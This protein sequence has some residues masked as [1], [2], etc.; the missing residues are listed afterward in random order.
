MTRFLLLCICICISTSSFSQTTV[1]KDVHFNNYINSL[2]NDFTNYFTGFNTGITQLQTNGI[3]GGCIATPDS[4]NWGNDNAH[5]CTKFKAIV[6][7]SYSFNTSFCFKYD[8]TI[9]NP[10]SFDR[11]ASIWIIPNADFN[12]YLI[13]SITHDKKIQVIS[14][15]S[16]MSTASMSLLHN[17]WYRLSS[18]VTFDGGVSGDVI[19]DLVTVYDLGPQGTST[20]SLVMLLNHLLND[21][22]LIADTSIDVSITG[23]RYGGALYIDDFHFEGNLGSD[24]CPLTGI[25]TAELQQQVVIKQEGN[26][27]HIKNNSSKSI[28]TAIYDLT[29]KMLNSEYIKPGDAEINMEH[30]SSGL[31]ILKFNDNEQQFSKRLEVLH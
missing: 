9:V 27:I 6:S 12:H 30:Y 5:F 11:V 31:Y 18:S 19:H 22:I 21:N 8:S 17:R 7:S 20:P 15:S 3:N 25:A 1:I 23:T 24:A 4:N 10:N 26:L 2:N 29:G 16:V 28:L 13:S 14:Y